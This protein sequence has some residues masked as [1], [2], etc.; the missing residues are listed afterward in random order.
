MIEDGDS[1][2]RENNLGRKD[3]VALGEHIEE[4]LS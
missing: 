4:G 1:N 3:A 2:Y